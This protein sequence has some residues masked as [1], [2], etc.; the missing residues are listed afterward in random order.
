MARK[1]RPMSREIS[2]ARPPEAAL[3][4]EVRW[5][6]DRGSMAYS[7]VTHPIFFASACGGRLSSTVATQS[8]LV[9]P[10]EKRHEPSACLI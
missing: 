7:A 4:R 3:L 5:C 8:T 9:L 1:L 2:C 10:M 6:P